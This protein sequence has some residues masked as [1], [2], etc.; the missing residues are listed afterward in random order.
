MKLVGEGRRMAIERRKEREGGKRGRED[1]RCPVPVLSPHYPLEL[2]SKPSWPLAHEILQKY[3]SRQYLNQ[4]CL[5]LHNF[6][7]SISPLLLPAV[8]TRFSTP[9]H[10]FIRHDDF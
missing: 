4:I 9:T 5:L 10:D 2:I 6:I 8:F 3:H 1:D 7:N